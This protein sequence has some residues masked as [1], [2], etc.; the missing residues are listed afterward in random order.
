MDEH[1][2]LLK[3]IEIAAKAVFSDESKFNFVPE[4]KADDNQVIADNNPASVK[5]QEQY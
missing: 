3:A 5:I 4:T 1:D 2:E